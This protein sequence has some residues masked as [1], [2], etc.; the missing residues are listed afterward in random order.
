MEPRTVDA[1]PDMAGA[2]SGRD[3]GFLDG[4]TGP[5]RDQAPARWV[6]DVKPVDA[7]EGNLA[8][9]A[10]VRAVAWPDDGM[11]AQ[12]TVPLPR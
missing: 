9:L 4:L 6:A 2:P 11:L 8:E 7:R 5:P 12:P 1:R 3:T 10:A